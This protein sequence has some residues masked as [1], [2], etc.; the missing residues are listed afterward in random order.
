[1]VDWGD[2]PAWVT[3]VVAFLAL[4]AAGLAY[5]T[6]SKQLRLQQTQLKDQTRVQEREQANQIDV[7]WQN[8][9]PSAW[10]RQS[11]KAGANIDKMLVVADNSKR[12]IH[13]VAC[14]LQR[15]AT[16]GDQEPRRLADAVSELGPSTPEH[17]EATFKPG[18]PS[19]AVIKAGASGGF[20]WSSGDMPDSQ[21]SQFWVRFTDDAGLHWEIDTDLHLEKLPKRDW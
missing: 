10:L 21:G 4:I 13:S 14:K 20:I 2:V 12:P 9:D 3:V 11:W 1:M 19:L 18:G 7:D 15:S 17:Q 8:L 16:S 6:Q 5:L